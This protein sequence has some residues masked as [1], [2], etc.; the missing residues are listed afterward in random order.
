MTTLIRMILGLGLLLSQLTAA[1][2]SAL[3]SAWVV[4]TDYS[5]LGRFQQLDTVSPWNISGALAEIPSDAIGR[6]HDGLLYIVGRGAA[7]TLQVYDPNAGHVLVREFSLGAGLNLQDIAFDADGLAYVSC[8]DQAVL[9]RVD[10]EAEQVLA[11]ISTVAFADADGLPETSWML[12]DGD[13]LYILSQ[14]L[15]INGWYAPT[16]PGQILVYDMDQQAWVDA[17]PTTAG[18]QP[19]ALQGWNP[20][21]RLEMVDTVAGRRLRAGCVGNY[22]V[23]DGGVEEVDPQ[24]MASVGFLVDETQLGGD[25]VSFASTGSGS[26]HV[27][28]SD[29]AFRTSLVRADLPGG[30]VQ[31]LDQGN[32]YVHTDLAWDG[33]ALVFVTDRTVAAAGLRVFDIFSGAELT[34]GPIATTL[35]PYQ[36]VMPRDDVSPVP[37]PLTGTNLRLGAPFPNPCNPAATVAVSGR[38]GQRVTVRLVDLRGRCVLDRTLDCDG[39]GRA[40]FRFDGHDG[41]GRALPAAAYRIV[42]QSPDGFAARTLIL[43]K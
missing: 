14:L 7:N 16:G 1:A 2:G 3:E 38:P 22:L 42:A 24:A 17:D 32:G 4:T 10:V 8:Y 21:P 43:V 26:V 28:V 11:S 12:A 35:P 6:H 25:I 31:V 30:G 9:L 36:I 5:S 40:E 37:T 33:G 39:R 19:I 13:R 20:Y 29:D 15:D 23:R 27:I 41:A 18:I 34:S